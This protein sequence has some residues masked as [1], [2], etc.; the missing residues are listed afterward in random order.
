MVTFT[1]SWAA[2]NYIMVWD[3]LTSVERLI[4][5]QGRGG[6]G[7]KKAYTHSRAGL[8]AELEIS[9]W[10]LANFRPFCPFAGQNSPWP[11]IMSRQYFFLACRVLQK[12]CTTELYCT[13]VCRTVVM[14]GR[15]R[16][17]LY[18]LGTI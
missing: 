9:S 17:W 8:A 14:Q 7:G 16:Q 12:S 3:N 11:D 2:H 10:P 18:G 13:A 1:Q 5:L 15:N 4:T 6:G